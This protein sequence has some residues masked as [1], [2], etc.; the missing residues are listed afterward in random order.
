MYII[1]RHFSDIVNLYVVAFLVAG[2]ET[3]MSGVDLTLRTLKES[4]YRH[5]CYGLT[6]TGF[7]NYAYCC[8]LRNIKRYTVYCLNDTL[9]GKE[10]CVEIFNLENIFIVLHL[11]KVCAL[12]YFSVLFLFK[13]LHYLC[14]C[15]SNRTD[16]LTGQIMTVC[17]L[18]CHGII[19]SSWGP[20]H[21]ASRRQQS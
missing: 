5:T 15:L 14:V 3:D 4:H 10:V 16:L 21:H 18:F 13:S 1:D 8:I 17:F 6:A 2:L 9:V 7:T 12:G 19:S 11:C 20:K